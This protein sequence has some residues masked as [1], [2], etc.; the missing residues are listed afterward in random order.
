[1]RV[2]G[3]RYAWVAGYTDRSARCVAEKRANRGFRSRY[4]EASP[5]CVAG[6]AVGSPGRGR[7]TLRA[8]PD[9]VA[10]TGF[11]LSLRVAYL[12]RIGAEPRRIQA[13]RQGELLPRANGSRCAHS[14]RGLRSDGA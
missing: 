10:C 13:T 8:Q 9:E 12:V 7:R 4:A 5:D 6:G 2:A 1:D 3:R 14:G 11:G